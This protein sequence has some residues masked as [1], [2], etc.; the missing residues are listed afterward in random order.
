M[1]RK[2]LQ[3][4]AEAKIFQGD[5]YAEAD[6]GRGSYILSND[7]DNIPWISHGRSRTCHAIEREG[8]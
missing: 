7:Q 1:W 6:V 5:T 4:V 3:V 8:D 2:T